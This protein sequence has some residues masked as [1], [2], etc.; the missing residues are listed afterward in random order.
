[1]AFVC[2]RASTEHIKCLQV[3]MFVQYLNLIIFIFESEAY[4]I[5]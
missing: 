4:V 1:M 2:E 3:F 5:L